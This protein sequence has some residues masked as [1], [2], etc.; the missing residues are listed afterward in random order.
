MKRGK[1]SKAT[2]RR[3]FIFGSFSFFLILYFSI[4]GIN[5]IININNL[6]N[7]Q[8]ELKGQLEMLKEEEA[9]L[10]TEVVKLQ[11]PDYIARYAREHYLYSK[12]DELLIRIEP[13]E[14]MVTNLPKHNYK[15]IAL[16]SIS[17]L[18][19]IYILFRKRK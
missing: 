6:G 10:K 12:D 17:S 15:Q 14:N 11:D 9:D 2:K 1:I 8:K 18:I 5:Y 7:Q 4:S 16:I 19:A 3:F 13:E